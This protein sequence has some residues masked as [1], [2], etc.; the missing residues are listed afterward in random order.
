MPKPTTFTGE[1]RSWRK[2]ES[3]YAGLFWNDVYKVYVDGQPRTIANDLI[4]NV[5]DFGD[6][7][8]LRTNSYVIKLLK[9]EELHE[10]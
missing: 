10:D 7:L 5:T 4:R 9:S 6:Y 8:L 1:L 3:G 2:T